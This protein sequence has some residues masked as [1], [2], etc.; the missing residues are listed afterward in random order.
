MRIETDTLGGK[1]DSNGGNGGK[2]GKGGKE[3]EQREGKLWECK[4]ESGQVKLCVA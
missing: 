1:H 4:G 2:G 3:G